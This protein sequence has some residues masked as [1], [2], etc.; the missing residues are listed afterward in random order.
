MGSCNGTCYISK[1]PIFDREDIVLILVRGTTRKEDAFKLPYTIET[2]EN[3]VPLGYPIYG[4]YDE[5]CYLKSVKNESDVLEYLQT[6]NF[7][8][9]NGE[10][11]EIE[12]INDTFITDLI[13]GIVR[14]FIFDRLVPVFCMMI[15]KKLYDR[16]M[17]YFSK[18]KSWNG[19]SYG[20]YL[21]N[22]ID[23]GCI[24]IKK[25]YEEYNDFLSK[26]GSWG[27][28]G[29]HSNL[30]EEHLE[31]LIRLYSRDIN[32]GNLRHECAI[33]DY[34][35]RRIVKGIG[36]EDKNRKYMLEIIT[37]QRILR[38]L[39]MGYY[40]VDGYGSQSREMAAHCEVARFI[41][42]ETERNI[43]R[44][45]KSDPKYYSKYSDEE[46]ASEYLG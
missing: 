10:K 27:L 33:F 44:F 39:R 34:L 15:K 46:L 41:L 1:M 32:I 40:S 7:T 36:D 14:L 19:V 28:S 22:S 9:P 8:Y 24:E 16:L 31:S 43:K 45:R 5:D 20:E 37:L 11:Y 17:K 2:W 35:I 12:S 4:V 3:Y 6:L 18:R 21:N 25:S 13:S 30:A 23:E 38:S 42:E 29:K 26:K